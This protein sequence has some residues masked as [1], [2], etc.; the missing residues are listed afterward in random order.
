MLA[1]SRP[2][3]APAILPSA[4]RRAR[5]PRT[6]CAGSWRRRAGAHAAGGAGIV[7]STLVA[8]GARVRLVGVVGDDEAGA[9][10]LGQ[11]EASGADPQGIVRAS[12]RPTTVKTRVMARGQQLIRLDRENRTPIGG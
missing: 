10:L 1:R 5:T 9:V 7:A 6:S 3:R 2:S 12:G 4:S 8:A 11:L